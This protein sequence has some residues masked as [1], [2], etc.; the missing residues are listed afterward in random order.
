MVLDQSA[1]TTYQQSF[2]LLFSLS[3]SSGHSSKVKAVQVEVLLVHLEYRFSSH[4]KFYSVASRQNPGSHQRQRA[5]PWKM[6]CLLKKISCSL[7]SHYWDNKHLSK[8]SGNQ[9]SLMDCECWDW[10]PRFILE[11][12]SQGPWPRLESFNPAHLWDFSLVATLSSSGSSMHW[13][14]DPTI[15]SLQMLS[16]LSFSLTIS[17]VKFEHCAHKMVLVGESLQCL[18]VF[19]RNNC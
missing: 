1:I 10:L 14:G 18:L 19:R 13:D 9:G 15:W 12:I 6:A 5:E 11:I 3:I 17:F 16:F 7:K 8:H 2:S 4:L